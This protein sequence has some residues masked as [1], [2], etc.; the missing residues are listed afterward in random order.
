MSMICT[1]SRIAVSALAALLLFGAGGGAAQEREIGVTSASRPQVTGRPP[2]TP[3]REL[4]L[5]TNVIHNERVTTTRDGQA[6][7]VF[8]DGSALTIGVNSE[9][10]LDSFVYDPDSKTGELAFAATKGIFRLVGGRISKQTPVIFKTPSGTI[11]IRG[12]VALIRL[13]ESG[14]LDATFLFGREMTVTNDVGTAEVRRPGFSITVPTPEAEPS[15]PVPALGANLQAAL[16]DLEGGSE[17]ATSE[18]ETT[19]V[20][21]GTAD[22]ST[23]DT[24][25]STT[26]LETVDSGD[27]EVLGDDLASEGSEL[28]PSLVEV[29]ETTTTTLSTTST[30]T[31][32]TTS[33]SDTTA[34]QEETN[35]TQ[36][37]QSTATTS[38][39]NSLLTLSTP[40]SGR[41]KH[42]TPFFLGTGDLFGAL[43]RGFFGGNVTGGLFEVQGLPLRLNIQAGAF[44][45][46]STAQPFSAGTLA[47]QGFLTP[48]LDFVLYE[49]VD[50]A[51][52]QRVLAWAG[53]PTTTLPT[54]GASFFALRNDFVLGSRIPFLPASEGGALVPAEPQSAADTAIVWN[55]SG[56]PSAHRPWA[57]RTIVI[58]GKGASQKSAVSV[59]IGQVLPGSG[60]PFL[61]GEMLGMSRTATNTQAQVFN[62][63]VAS[64]DDGLGNDFFGSAGPTRFVL[65]AAEVDGNDNI[66]MRG[67]K[68]PIGG[69]ISTYFPNNVAVAV[70]DTVGTRRSRSMFGYSGGA[71]QT[72]SPAGALVGTILFHNETARKPT[73]SAA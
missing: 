71:L 40:F 67:A 20:E 47:G 52:S 18:Q 35:V 69:V 64:S 6:Q 33:S 16:D 50:S 59:M 37:S 8:H 19:T 49:L 2:V 51:N 70:S 34:I 22:T 36:A 45:A 73:R 5:G 14:R 57:H 63:E 60:Q 30:T 42:A 25:V 12:G 32:T 15:D 41:I 1:P 11:G 48:A 46:K 56:S 21:D 72:I 27:V 7:M 53:V 4:T 61:T 38:T 31:T 65:E 29:S 39:T 62:A 26:S 10:V 9:V 3:R 68:G 23:T 28:D 58:S 54:T 13:S 17:P 66:L 44:P 43:N 24:D 55:A